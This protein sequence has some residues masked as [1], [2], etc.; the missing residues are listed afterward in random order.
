MGEEAK[1][2]RQDKVISVLSLLLASALCSYYSQ[3]PSKSYL[4]TQFHSCSEIQGSRS[5]TDLVL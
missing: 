5:E 1:K 3:Q 2:P 4:H